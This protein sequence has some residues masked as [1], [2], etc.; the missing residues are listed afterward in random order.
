M[1]SYSGVW[2]LTAVYQ[3]VGA[4]NWTNPPPAKGLFAGGATTNVIA[5]VMIDTTGNAIDF[6][7]L[8]VA[9]YGAAGVASTT[10]GVFMSGQTAVGYSN[11]IDYV[12]IS[13]SGNAIDFG[14]CTQAIYIGGN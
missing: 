1:P 8:T 2:T 9:R 6:G 10:R 5:Y 14:D 11:V 4:N 13:T 7:D 3:A 12:T